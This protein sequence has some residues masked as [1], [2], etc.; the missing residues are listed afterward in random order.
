MRVASHSTTEPIKFAAIAFR[1]FAFPRR[2]VMRHRFSFFRQFQPQF[3]ARLR[4]A[5][6]RL[7][8]R[9]RAAK[10]AEKENFNL[11]H[12]AVVPYLQQVADSNLA[13]SLGLL[14]VGFN[15]AEFTCPCRE[16]TGLEESG[17]P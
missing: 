13:G 2:F 16:R 17:C 9:C 5:I 3:P 6:E 15:S 12:A 10:L 1:W 7:R 14:S 11:K 4:L 8:D